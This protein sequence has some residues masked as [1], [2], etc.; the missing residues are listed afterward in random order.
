VAER[1]WV[2]AD[3][4]ER[5]TGERRPPTLGQWVVDPEALA[6]DRRRML[7]KV[8]AAGSVGLDV[9]KL[10]ER[11]RAVVGDLVAT[12]EATLRHGSARCAGTTPTLASH[13]YL[14]ALEKAPFAPP[15]AAE[16]GVSRAE[17]RQLLAAGLVVERDGFHFAASALA[18]GVQLVAELLA[19]SPEGVTV[20]AVRERLG[21]TRKYVLPFL[22]LLDA[23][24][25]TRR[26]G[27]LRVAGP[28]LPATAGL[29]TDERDLAWAGER[30]G[31]G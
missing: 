23:E 22:S 9:A 29:P 11:E 15:D 4:L 5:L 18:R 21:T 25:I 6:E 30:N 10:D 27:D 19:G 1:R 28:R 17:L 31:H 20:S 7:E 12:G 16:L 3:L 24:G 26:R 8:A 13:P 14:R 2:A